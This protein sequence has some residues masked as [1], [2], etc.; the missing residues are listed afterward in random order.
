VPLG[1]LLA[2]ALRDEVAQVLCVALPH[3]EIEGE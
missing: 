2:E 1:L 3:C